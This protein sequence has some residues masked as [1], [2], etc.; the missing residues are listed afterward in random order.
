MGRPSPGPWRRSTGRQLYPL[1]KEHGRCGKYGGFPPQDSASL[2]IGN[3]VHGRRGGQPHRLEQ[4]LR[5]SGKNDGANNVA[6]TGDG[7]FVAGFEESSKGT[8]EAS[9]RK[10][11]PA[12]GEL[13]WTTLLPSPNSNMDSAFESI[14]ITADGG[15]IVGGFIEGVKGGMEGFKS[16]GNP[17]SGTAQITYFSAGQ[18]AGSSAPEAAEWEKNH[19][20]YGS[21]RNILESPEG[22]F[23][24]PGCL[25]GRR[26][27]LCRCENR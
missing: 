27:S 1:R 22:G 2:S 15:A 16:Y 12:T 5:T 11:D 9:L 18:L 26:R 20:A 6:V 14:R 10:I 3:P 8:A 19:S 21:I 24:F 4:D 17:T 23:V 7:V 13:I 25:C